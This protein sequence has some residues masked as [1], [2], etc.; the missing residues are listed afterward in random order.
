[1]KVTFYLPDE[2]NLPQLITL[3]PDKDWKRFRK[4]QRWTVQTYIRLK[5]N[6]NKVGISNILPEKGIVVYQQR[7]KDSLK[8]ELIRR[9][10]KDLVLV[11]I[12]GDKSES[13]IADF[14][15][16]Q[17]D[18][19]ADNKRFFHIPYWPQPGLIPRDKRRK[20]KVE[21]IAFKGFHQNLHDYF[22]NG[23][24]SKWLV[25][26]N[27]KWQ[28]DSQEF[29]S[30]E[31]NGVSAD[32]HDYRNVDVIVAMRP[33]PKRIDQKNG[34]TAKPATKLY[35][36]W[37]AGV[38]ALLAPEYA[39]QQLRKSELDYIEVNS[40]QEVKDAVIKLQSNPDLYQAMVENGLN[41]ATDY[42]VEQI[43]S[44][45]EDFLFDQ[46]PKLI[47]TSNF[48][49]NKMIPFQLKILI[50]RLQRYISGR[51]KR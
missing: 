3:D 42:S 39:F 37:H 30:S 32:W 16:L 12:R 40:I 33:K 10:I 20:N 38:P 6:G 19:W 51:T 26:N 13:L 47:G 28:L 25:N 17:N 43:L 34:F 2:P 9:K 4:G 46:L 21:T 11:C 24:W 14:E 44:K 7:H 36:S 27:M 49:R 48:K 35:N 8:K 5:R 1:M 18:K 15:I 45:W 41:R 50:R 29:Y 31:E 22:L 23:K